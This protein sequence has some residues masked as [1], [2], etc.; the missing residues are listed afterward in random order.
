MIADLGPPLPQIFRS[1]DRAH[2]MQ[3]EK[4]AVQRAVNSLGIRFFTSEPS[5]LSDAVSVIPVNYMMSRSR[6]T[7]T[8]V[9]SHD[10]MMSALTS[11]LGIISSSSPPDDW[12]FF[13]IESYVFA[14]GSSHVSVV[15][16]RVE[17]QRSR[18]RNTGKLCEPGSLEG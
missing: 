13:P 10:N 5:P 16:M 15:R 17:I 7:H 3:S 9:V 1:G 14:F 18:R 4:S 6:G 12:A 2:L 11:S 8:I